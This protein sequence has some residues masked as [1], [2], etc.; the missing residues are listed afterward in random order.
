MSSTFNFRISH[1]AVEANPLE[2]PIVVV[3]SRDEQW[4]Y[5]WQLIL[6]AVF[7]GVRRAVIVLAIEPN[8]EG[9]RAWPMKFYQ[10]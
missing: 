2:T 8:P 4:V 6:E 9:L 7:C 10:V 5:S 1:T 3:P